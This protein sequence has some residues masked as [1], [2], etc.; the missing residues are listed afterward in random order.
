[1]KNLIVGFSWGVLTAFS[2]VYTGSGNLKTA[3]WI[4]FVFFFSYVF[5]GSIIPD[6]RDREGDSLA[7]IRTIPVLIGPEK[8]NRL[9]TGMNLLVGAAVFLVSMGRE[10][11][12]ILLL[13]TAGFLYTHF[14]IQLFHSS[15]TK[16]FVTDFLFD[17]QYILFG[18]V[19]GLLTALRVYG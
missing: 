8:T 9:L 14:C 7:G 10:S 12:R 11:L 5:I 17:G 2:P 4:C 6:I 16:N 18:L 13:L 15:N 3:S 19:L 1:M